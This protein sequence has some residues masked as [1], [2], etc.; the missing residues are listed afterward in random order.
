QGRRGRTAASARR[1]GRT[2]RRDAAAW[3][4]DLAAERGEEVDRAVAGGDALLAR[5]AEGKDARP[6][7]GRA[8]VTEPAQLLED[9]LLVARRG[10]VADVVGLAGRQQPLVVR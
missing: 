7:V 1:R 8:G 5:A 2:A 6:H 4:L 3:R 10:H 9:R